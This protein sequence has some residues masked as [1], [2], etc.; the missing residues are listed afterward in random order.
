MRLTL[1]NSLNL[2]TA[3]AVALLLTQSLLFTPWWG[4]GATGR[5][6]FARAMTDPAR[7]LTA[8]TRGPANE[9][10]VIQL[11]GATLTP[12]DTPFTG[13]TLRQ[14]RKRGF[15]RAEVRGSEGQLVLEQDLE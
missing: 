1:R 15:T 10:L 11:P 4:G 13:S 2:A 5:A 8:W 3:T 14:L 7:G 6:E 12:A 9:V